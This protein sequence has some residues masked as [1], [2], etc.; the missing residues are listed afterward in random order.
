MLENPK[1]RV[2]VWVLSKGFRISRV[3]TREILNSKNQTILEEG[4]RR[5]LTGKRKEDPKKAKTGISR[6]SVPWIQLRTQ[7]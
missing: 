6:F 3:C 5:L 4:R 7:K 2:A 1:G